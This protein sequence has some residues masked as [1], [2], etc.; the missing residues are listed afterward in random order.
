M[1]ESLIQF[2]DPNA[3]GEAIVVLGGLLSVKIELEPLMQE[4]EEIRLRNRELMQQTQ[5]AQQQQ[6]RMAQ[7]TLACTSR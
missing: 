4:A 1:A 6:Q 7:M 3:A 2:P 5:E